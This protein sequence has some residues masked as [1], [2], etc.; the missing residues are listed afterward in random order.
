M[1][2]YIRAAMSC[3]RI[4]FFLFEDY[5]YQFASFI[6]LCFFVP[7]NAFI[8]LYKRIVIKDFYYI[9]TYLYYI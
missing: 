6:Y 2:L 1:T 8:K 5:Y 7:D 3:Y 4:V 9:G